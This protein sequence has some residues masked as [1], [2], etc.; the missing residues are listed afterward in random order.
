M[1]YILAVIR[2]CLGIRLEPFWYDQPPPM[3]VTNRAR[4]I[5]IDDGI[6]EALGNHD[7]KL[8]VQRDQPAVEG[9]IE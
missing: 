8:L 2:Q 6:S 7:S 3:R 4:E 5:G 1:E 9:A